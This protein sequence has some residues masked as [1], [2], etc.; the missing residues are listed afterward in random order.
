MRN[1][2]GKVTVQCFDDA[3]IRFCTVRTKA[4]ALARHKNSPTQRVSCNEFARESREK[5]K[6]RWQF[7]I[8]IVIAL[9]F[10]SLRGN[11]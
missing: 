8:R 3:S 6:K 7:M 2:N 4:S 11:R 1:D 10:N 9:H 5:K